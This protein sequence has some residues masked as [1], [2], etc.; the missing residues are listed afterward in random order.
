MK[1]LHTIDIIYKI[2]QRNPL[3]KEI[4]LAAYKYV[5]QCLDERGRLRIYRIKCDRS[6]DIRR[7]ILSLKIPKG[8]D[9]GFISKIKMKDESYRHIPQIDFECPISNRNLNKIKRKLSEIVKIFPGYILNSGASYHYIGLRLLNEKE[10][11][12]FNGLCL[13]CKEPKRESLIDVRWCGHRL[14]SG[15]SNL[16]ILANDSRPEPKVVVFLKTLPRR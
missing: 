11:Q 8:W 12:R 7:E 3:I 5:P 6:T 16:R 13:L 14:L 10:W 2:I 1:N 9:L 4:N 15:Y